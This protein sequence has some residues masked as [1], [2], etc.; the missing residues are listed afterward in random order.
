MGQK[1][2]FTWTVVILFQLFSDIYKY[3][4]TALG[5]GL[6]LIASMSACSLHVCKTLGDFSLLMD[7]SLVMV[8]NCHYLLSLLEH[9]MMR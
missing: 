1:L 6:S 5:Q 7:Y 4:N 2:L 8:V 9:D 3:F